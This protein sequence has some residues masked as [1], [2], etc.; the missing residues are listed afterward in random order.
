[1]SSTPA[2]VDELYPPAKNL[3]P[4]VTKEEMSIIDQGSMQFTKKPY[5][6]D[7]GGPPKIESIKFCTL[8]E[9]EILKMSEV[10]VWRGIYYNDLRKPE[11]SGL[12]LIRSSYER[13][14]STS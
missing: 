4:H 6:E 5:V 12:L 10:Q 1:M 9:K 2:T 14:H 8:S 3:Y 11:A 13:L 7:I